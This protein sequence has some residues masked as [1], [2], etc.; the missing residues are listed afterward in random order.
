MISSS[1][2]RLKRGRDALGVR[3][4]PPQSPGSFSRSEPTIRRDPGPSTRPNARAGGRRRGGS[5]LP[6]VE[7]RKET[8]SWHERRTRAEQPQASQKLALT[9][10]TRG[11]GKRRFEPAPGLGERGHARSRGDVWPPRR[12]LDGCERELRLAARDRSELN[13]NQPCAP[14]APNNAARVLAQDRGLV[15]V[16]YTPRAG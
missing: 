2:F 1:R 14:P 12:E 6:I 15:R 9:G 13:S 7:P 11:P 4:G 10:M 5:K 8:P 16:G 3:R